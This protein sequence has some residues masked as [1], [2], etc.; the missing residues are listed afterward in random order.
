M[1][2]IQTILILIQVCYQA[3]RF[4]LEI[5]ETVFDS[6]DVFEKIRTKMYLWP[7]NIEMADRKYYTT[8]LETWSEIIERDWIKNRTYTERFDCDKYSRCFIAHCLEIYGLN[9]IG[10][11]TGRII[12]QVDEHS[13]TAF[14]DDN[15][16]VYILEPQTGQFIKIENGKPVLIGENYYGFRKISL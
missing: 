6:R 15:L 9:S 16:D 10:L 4:N 8:N 7:E 13:F 12:G 11:I 5:K 1:S 3:L 2:F 14:F